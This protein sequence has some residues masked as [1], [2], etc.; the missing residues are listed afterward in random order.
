[1]KK[2]LS[3]SISIFL[4]YVLIFVLVVVFALLE[5]SRVWC[6]EQRTEIDAAM[7]ENSLAAEYNVPLWNEYG[8]LFLDGGYGENALKISYLEKRGLSFATEN[9]SVHGGETGMIEAR[10]WNLL[11]LVPKSLTVTGY[12]LATD[13]GGR[14]FQLE[15]VKAMESQFTEEVLMELYQTMTKEEN[16]D[17]R[18]VSVQE[19][20]KEIVIQENP[21]EAVNGMKKR[22]IL[23]LVVTEGEVSSK[24]IDLE[25]SLSK[26]TLN[27]GTISYSKTSIGWSEKILFRQ[28]LQKY[29]PCFVN[30]NGNHALDYELEYLLIGKASDK[31]NLQGVLNRLLAVRELSN[32]Q[33]LRTNPEKQEIILA[34]ATAL[35]ALTLSPELIPAYKTGIMAAW[36]Y[37]E[38]ISDL[39]LLLDGQKVSM[40]K[41]KD[42]WHT[43]VAGL[44]KGVKT[45]EIKQTQGLSYQEYIQ[46]FMW[47]MKDSVLAYRAMDLIEKNT[48]VNMNC[49][50]Y[51]A[52]GV[53]T[54]QGDPLFS[55]I[56]AVGRGQPKKYHFS[57]VFSVRY[58]QE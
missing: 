56:I 58:I 45:K 16:F 24:Q 19:T 25:Q 47:T 33:F 42:Q 57:Q 32:L 22:G 55:S 26:R 8:L 7:T 40:V 50:I 41:T 9:M 13:Q 54:Y 23:S 18:E 17:E 46:M 28:Y 52:D 30:V 15:A 53:V 51:R 43:D 29:Y 1:M 20:T 2:Q 44:S 31:Q 6:L 12:G 34:A 38:S 5:V 36:A 11:G 27:K 14:A 49:Q 3:G 10:S 35:A 37:A 48:G 39:R 4:A 21:I